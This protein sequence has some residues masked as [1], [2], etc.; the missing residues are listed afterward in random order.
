MYA[1]RTY[2]RMMQCAFVRQHQAVG[3]LVSPSLRI[4]YRYYWTV[5]PLISSIQIHPYISVSPH[6]CNVIKFVM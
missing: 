6:G 5:D 3:W 4:V 1:Y 2:L